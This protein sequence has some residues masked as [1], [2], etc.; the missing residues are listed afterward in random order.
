M[1]DLYLSILVTVLQ[2][3]LDV[4]TQRL[5]FLLGEARHDGKQHL[6][7]GIHR[8]LYPPMLS[9]NNFKLPSRCL[10]IVSITSTYNK[11]FI[12]HKYYICGEF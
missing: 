4:L 2:A 3:Q 8:I 7:L 5:A 12:K 11:N 6:A 10:S 1:V 9:K